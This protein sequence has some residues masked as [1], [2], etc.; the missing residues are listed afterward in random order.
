MLHAGGKFGGGGYKVSGGLHGV[1]VSVVNALS[2][3]LVVEV[4]N[5]GHEWRQTLH[6]RRP[7]RSAG[8]G[9]PDGARRAHRHHRDLL[10]LQDDLRDH[11]VLPRDDHEPVPRVRLPQQ[12]SRDRGARRAGARRGVRAGPRG[13]PDAA[14]GCRRDRRHRGRRRAR[15]GRCHGAA[16]PLRPGSRRLRRAP[17]PSQG[18]GQP[19]GDQ[20]RG[21][22]PREPRAAD[23]P[24][25]RDAVE[26]LLPGVGP[27]LRQHDQHPRGRHPRGGLP[28]GAHRPW[29]T[30]GARS[31]G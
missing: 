9:A 16:V 27:H 25:G 14:R 15:R 6:D 18:Q 19:D 21:L 13:R 29:S 22:D 11:D 4:R 8:A 12:G 24:R 1:G 3:H 2:S 28:L 5:R 31:G 20:L 26:H 17:Q 23:E 7:G 10:G 30:T